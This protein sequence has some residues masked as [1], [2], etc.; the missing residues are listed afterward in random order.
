[1]FPNGPWASVHLP[2][3]TDAAHL[4]PQALAA[5]RWP[6]TTNFTILKTRRVRIV[7]KGTES[8]VP[9]PNYTAVLIET[10]SGQ[11]IVLL[12][13]NITDWLSRVYDV[14]D[15]PVEQR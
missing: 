4:V 2:A 7:C 12:Q 11:K 13:F 9:D 5:S 8:V 10:H 1:M 6:A 15:L 3:E 14:H